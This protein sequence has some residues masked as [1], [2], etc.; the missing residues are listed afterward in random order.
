MASGPSQWSPTRLALEPSRA[1]ATSWATDGFSQMTRDDMAAEVSTGPADPVP[2]T[3]GHCG[4]PLSGAGDDRLDRRYTSSGTVLRTLTASE[5][6]MSE[7]V[8]PVRATI[9]PKLPVGDQLGGARAEAR[10]QRAVEGGRRAAALH[11][12]EHH[13]AGLAADLRLDVLGEPLA[14][15]RLGQQGVAELVDLAL[16]GARPRASTP[17]LTTTI[18]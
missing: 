8:S 16:V 1:L 5:R 11:V 3:R 13:R 6:G 10:G 15:A 14:H 12:S 9:R 4:R 2:G 7:T 17:S 18:A